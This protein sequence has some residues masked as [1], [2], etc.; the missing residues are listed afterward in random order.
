MLS[1][2][3]CVPCGSCTWNAVGTLC[4]QGL[5]GDKSDTVRISNVKALSGGVCDK[6]SAEA[7]DKIMRGGDALQP[8]PSDKDAPEGYWIKQET[9]PL[10]DFI[11]FLQK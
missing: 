5:I 3:L 11:N 1:V 2:T 4:A 7:F 10:A 6:I 8:P 9:V